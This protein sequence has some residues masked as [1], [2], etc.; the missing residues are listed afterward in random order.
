MNGSQPLWQRLLKRATTLLPARPPVRGKRRVPGLR[1]DVRVTWTDGGIPHIDADSAEDLFFAQGYLVA[2]DRLFQMD[3]LRRTARGELAEV[4]G[5]RA[6]PWTEMSVVFR[7]SSLVDLDHFLR[8]L[9]L[10]PVARSSVDTW[11]SETRGLVDAYAAGVNAWIESGSTPLEMQ[12]LGYRPR[13]WAAEDCALAWKFLAFQL[14]YG[15]RA[16]LAAEALR[17]RFPTDPSKARALVPDQ[18][19]VADVLLPTWGGAADLLARAEEIAGS[20]SPGGSGLGGSN[21][22]A[23]APGRT[24]SGRAIVCGDPHLPMRAPAPGWLAH[25]RGGGFDVAGWCVPGIPGVAMGH[26]DRVAWSITSGCTLDATWT[27]E[28]LA[29]DGESVRVAGGF[30]PVEQE[31]TEIAVRGEKSAVRR[32]LRHTPN[33]PLFDGTL[34]G[35]APGGYG[36]A[37]RWTGHL[38]TPDLEVLLGI[39]RAHDVSAVRQATSRLGAPALSLVVADVDGHVGW[40]LAGLAPKFRSKPPL[41]AVPAWAP[42]HEWDG[43]E[44]FE[45]LP[46]VVD[47]PEGLVISA[48]QRIVPTGAALQ[49]GE[50]F[51]PPYRARRIRAL[52]RSRGRLGLDEA[53]APQLDRYSGF[54]VALRDV[55]NGLRK[56]IDDGRAGPRPEGLAADVLMLVTAWDGHATPSSR[57]AAA[58]TAFTL[59]LVRELFHDALGERLFH[60]VFEQHDL[61]L[62]PLLRVLNEGGRPF[63]DPAQLDEALLRSLESAGKMLVSACGGVESWR[64]G[65]I[66][67]L[68]LRHPL[69]G[70]P[71][72]GVLAT[73]GPFE[74]GGDGSTPN[75]AKS[76]L[77]QGGDVDVGPVFRHAVECGDWDN[78]RVVLATGQGGDPTTGRY[79][80]HLERWLAGGHVVLPF[81]AP[82]IERAAT[83]HA[84]LRAEGP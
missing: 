75:A 56:R 65:A 12:L 21:A 70:V 67:R 1:R 76:R 7:G 61:P 55:L 47:P 22:W 69:S 68:V 73:L 63:L 32:R 4:F 79:R 51:E 77:D 40:Q 43:I 42:E 54:G 20:G 57:G 52:L 29:T 8:Q 5:A 33:G 30:A 31:W 49:L 10:V 11:S 74:W 46:F 45:A 62:M 6:A 28:Q 24:R 9:S 37:L 83:D 41:G 81:T 50:L 18:R 14:C 60:A 59:A 27:M 36:L 38:P 23:L 44:P 64:L 66:R 48:N 82:A 15:W 26:N 71:G 2:A 13:R 58:S 17:A 72:L 25:L 35:G 34:A 53:A 3:L 16:G 80:E 78:Y 84:T 39:D 19:D